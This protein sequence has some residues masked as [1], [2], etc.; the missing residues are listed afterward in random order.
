[1]SLLPFNHHSRQKS[2]EENLMHVQRKRL[3][4]SSK[5]R[6][7]QPETWIQHLPPAR[8]LFIYQAILW[9]VYSAVQQKHAACHKEVTQLGF[10]ASRRHLIEN[11]N[12]LRE[13]RGNMTRP[14]V[15]VAPPRAAVSC[16][17]TVWMRYFDIIFANNSKGPSDWI[18]PTCGIY[19]YP[20]SVY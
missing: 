9:V 19:F 13:K 2:P 16:K 7:V 14:I 10:P 12:P 11:R 8:P 15:D 6:R 18:T 3:S 4:K 5:R 1:M 20:S 17:K